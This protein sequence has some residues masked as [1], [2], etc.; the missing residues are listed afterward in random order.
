MLIDHALPADNHVNDVDHALLQ[1]RKLLDTPRRRYRRDTGESP[2]ERT[3][4]TYVLFR[5]YNF[6]FFLTIKQIWQSVAHQLLQ[7]NA[8]PSALCSQIQLETFILI[9]TTLGGS[10]NGF[11]Q[12]RLKTAWKMQSPVMGRTWSKARRTTGMVRMPVLVD[13][14][15]WRWEHN[16]VLYHISVI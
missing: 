9:F 6:I 15:S 13:W 10:M 3:G 11:P 5:L 1:G 16:C 4:L 8:F 14:P 12:P 7:N 2:S